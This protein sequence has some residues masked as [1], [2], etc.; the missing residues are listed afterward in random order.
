[1]SDNAQNDA[2]V[3]DADTSDAP[4][5]EPVGSQPPPLPARAK[6]DAEP[7]PLKT[8]KNIP[9]RAWP[10]RVLADV[11]TRKVITVREDEAVGDLEDWMGRFGFHHLP[12]VTA[13]MKLVGLITRTD[14]LHA[15][16]GKTPDGKPAAAPLI[17]ETLAGAIMRR[18]VVTGTPDTEL[19]M[20]CR[21]MIQEKLG[22]LPIVQP[23]ATLVGIV[24]LVDIVQVAAALLERQAAG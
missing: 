4:E 12:V 15:A 1:M 18:D 13:E 11:M 3:T 24:T 10:P 8:T 19:L 5:L 20:A 9:A 23:D 7:E 22:S 17:K 16:L 6:K 14:Y 21:V 2:P